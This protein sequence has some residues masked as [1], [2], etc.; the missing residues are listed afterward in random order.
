[1]QNQAYSIRETANN[2]YANFI[3][4]NPVER[5]TELVLATLNI[6][7]ATIASGFHDTASYR[8]SNHWPR[9]NEQMQREFSK[10]HA[11]GSIGVSVIVRQCSVLVVM[12]TQ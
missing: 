3:V 5:A 4:S 10:I 2:D 8:R 6:W 12:L 9:M 11:I 7:N 1:M